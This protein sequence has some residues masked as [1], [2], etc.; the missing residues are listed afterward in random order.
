MPIEFFFVERLHDLQFLLSDRRNPAAVALRSAAPLP[1]VAVLLLMISDDPFGDLLDL[2]ILCLQHSDLRELQLALII[3]RRVDQ[4]QLVVSVGG[5]DCRL[6]ILI[7][8]VH[9]KFSTDGARIPHRR[10]CG[11]TCSVVGTD[12]VDSALAELPE[13]S[14]GLP[15]CVKLQFIIPIPNAAAAA[16]AMI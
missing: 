12:V 2:W 1:A 5:L 3:K 11:G 14:A 8:S 9:C 13:A 10:H 6:H 16:M 4:E 7:R 15:A